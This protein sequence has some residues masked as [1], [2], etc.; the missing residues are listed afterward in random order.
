MLVHRMIL[1]ALLGCVKEAMYEHER[2]Y[3]EHFTDLDVLCKHLRT[4][5]HKFLLWESHIMKP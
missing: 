5:S 2:I 1:K 4:Q 3:L